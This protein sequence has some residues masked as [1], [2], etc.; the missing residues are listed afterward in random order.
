M[1]LGRRLLFRVTQHSKHV[2]ASVDEELSG[3][4]S[5]IG[6]EPQQAPATEQDRSHVRQEAYL[7]GMLPPVQ[8]LKVTGLLQLVPEVTEGITCVLNWP[9]K[10]EG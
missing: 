8:L 1:R 10:S 5:S 7:V 2:C 3:H 6:H 4:L 9:L